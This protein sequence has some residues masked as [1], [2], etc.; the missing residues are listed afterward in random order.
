MTSR[1]E[2]IIGVYKITNKITGKY[3]IGY[4]KNIYER[5]TNHRRFL[6]NNKHINIKLQ[7]SYNKH[8]LEAFTFEILHIF[9][10]IEEAFNSC[11]FY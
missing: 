7:R 4:S 11:S 5:W 8:T 10:N 3:Y 1:K 6:K 9:D 2:I